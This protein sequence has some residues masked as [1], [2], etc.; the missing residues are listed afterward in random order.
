ASDYAS[1][2]WGRILRHYDELNRI[3]PSPVVA[4][5]RAVAVA[6]VHGPRAGLEAIA[7]IPHRDRLESHYLLHAVVGELELRLQNHRAAAES[8]RR[9]LQLS[10]VGPEQLYL[11]RMLERSEDVS[12]NCA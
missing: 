3:K 11:T 12:E 8:F 7:A 10:Q 2:D 1:T 9:A 5:N 6:N 4:L